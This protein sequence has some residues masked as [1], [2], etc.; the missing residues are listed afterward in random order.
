MN[1]DNNSL[2]NNNNSNNN[3]NNNKRIYTSQYPIPCQC[4]RL[5]LKIKIKY[6]NNNNSINNN[7][8]NNNHKTVQDSRVSYL[9]PGHYVHVHSHRGLQFYGRPT[10]AATSMTLSYDIYFS[11]GFDFVKVRPE[12]S[13]TRYGYG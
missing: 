8:N 5:A 3:N 9:T 13:D 2:S 12:R 11:P 4:I 7:S 10:A 1:N 6:N